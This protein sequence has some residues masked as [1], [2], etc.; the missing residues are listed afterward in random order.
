[1]IL[2][3]K[4]IDV[5]TTFDKVGIAEGDNHSKRSNIFLVRWR[6]KEGNKGI[7]EYRMAEIVIYDKRTPMLLL[8][9]ITGRV[10]VS[11]Y[12]Q[13]NEPNKP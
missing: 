5:K 1:M 4:Y 12:S 2:W 11:H 7:W 8:H 3:K 9:G 13:I 10:E 6:W